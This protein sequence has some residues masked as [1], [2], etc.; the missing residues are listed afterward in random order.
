MKYEQQYLR[1]NIADGE[2]VLSLLPSL[3]SYRGTPYQEPR[4]IEKQDQRQ[5]PEHACWMRR[6][7]LSE[8]D[9]PFSLMLF[10]CMGCFLAVKGVG[11][12]AGSMAH[13]AWGWKACYQLS[14][15]GYLLNA[16]GGM[17]LD[18]ISFVQ[19]VLPVYYWSASLARFRAY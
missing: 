11:H 18:V 5:K 12:G 16:W 17:E 3:Y 1:Y 9:S 4:H 14:A 13:G 6:A 15:D 10:V 19:N 2:F 7:N 8:V